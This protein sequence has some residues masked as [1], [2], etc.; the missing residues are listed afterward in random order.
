VKRL[1]C[2]GLAIAVLA[3]AAPMAGA[4]VTPTLVVGGA[5]DQITPNVDDGT[6]LWARSRSGDAGKYDVLAQ[7][8]TDAPFKVNPDGT[9]G[10]GGSIEGSQAIY[11]QVSNDGTSSDVELFDL[12]TQTTSAPAGVNTGKWE[13]SPSMSGGYILFG[14]NDF[15]LPRSP[16]KVILFNT[17]D[18]SRV[19]LGKVRNDCACIFPGQVLDGIAT[20]TKCVRTCQAYWYDVAT[21]TTHKI[22][23]PNAEAQYFPAPGPGGDIYFVRGGARCGQNVRLMRFDPAAASGSEFTT[24]SALA[25]GQDV[26]TRTYVDRDAGG[27]EDLYFDQLVCSGGF[28]ADI[29]VV[30]DAGSVAGPLTHAPTAPLRGA[31]ARPQVPGSHP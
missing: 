21:L 10:F 9:Q 13:W 16:W 17:G 15:S 11:Q 29:Y 1:F 2:S 19:V 4:V 6:V 28:D 25:S 20:W 8:G 31:V 27:H 24:L 26:S 22:P 3:L 23:N 18:R 14:R 5:G 30:Q 12:S 7:I